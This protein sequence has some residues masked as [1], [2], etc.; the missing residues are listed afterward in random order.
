M[1]QDD[2]SDLSRF[3]PDRSVHVPKADQIKN[4]PEQRITRQAPYSSSSMQ[5]SNAESI[6]LTYAAGLP[7]LQPPPRT[8]TKN[9]YETT[10]YSAGGTAQAGS[11]P[12]MPLEG[13]TFVPSRT[14]LPAAARTQKRSVLDLE[15]VLDSVK[16]L[17]ALITTDTEQVGRDRSAGDQSLRLMLSVMA[18]EMLYLSVYGGISGE[19]FADLFTKKVDF[20]ANIKPLAEQLISFI[21]SHLPSDPKAYSEVMA[22]LIESINSHQSLESLLKATQVLSQALA[23]GEL[24]E[25]KD[26]ATGVE[27]F[28]HSLDQVDQT[29]QTIIASI[30]Q[31]Y[32]KNLAEFSERMK[33]ADIQAWMQEVSDRGA[34][35]PT[36]YYAFI[37]AKSS[38]QTSDGRNALLERF[39]QAFNQ[40]VIDPNKQ[41]YLGGNA[42]DMMEAYPT[43]SFIAGCMVCGV[44]IVREAI[45]NTSGIFQHQLQDNPIADVLFSVAPGIVLYPDYQAAAALIVALLN[46]GAV[47]K[48]TEDAL[49][50]GKEKG[51]PPHDLDFAIKYAKHIIAI[52]THKSVLSHLQPKEIQER[53]RLVRLM[54]SVMALNMLYRSAY[55]GMTG[56]EFGAILKGETQDIHDKIKSLIEQLTGLVKANLPISQEAR[57]ETILRLMDY[58]DSKDSIDSM[59]QSTRILANLLSTKDVDQRRWE[60]QSG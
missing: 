7:V 49:K 3:K 30:W 8:Q 22:K 4:Q 23:H 47:Y 26:S 60:A 44:D 41:A 42:A 50:K 20:P 55:G 15:E 16:N 1:G 52:V 28:M 29:K 57:A 56:E 13:Q 12:P 24:L 40:W 51:S 58:V 19:E 9:I 35:S 36:E 48:A 32:S 21:K 25:P 38:M 39:S 6:V 33:G 27:V 17:L 43:S 53:D 2:I 34:Q 10:A 18:L 59:L 45:K 46:N 54:L 37:L 14:E 31:N 5:K 11:A